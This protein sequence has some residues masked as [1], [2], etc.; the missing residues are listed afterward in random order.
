MKGFYDKFPEFIKTGYQ[1]GKD[2]LNYRHK[3]LIEQNKEIIE[4]QRVLDIA[5]HDGRFTLP[6]LLAG[7]SHVT[8]I[9]ARPELVEASEI[10]M[11]LYEADPDKYNFICGDV[12]EEIEKLD[13]VDVVFCF[14]F[15]YHTVNQ[16]KL[17]ADIAALEPKYLIVDTAVCKHPQPIFMLRKE[18]TEKPLNSVGDRAENIVMTPNRKTLD[19]IFKHYGFEPTYL[20]LK[21]TLSIAYNDDLRLAVRCKKV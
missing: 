4:G 3:L 5:S 13:D 7:A 16:F 6:A 14:G 2:R 20:K 10:N 17:L 11:K 19:V 15:F 8:G 18:S 1:S 21:D 12:H 9:E